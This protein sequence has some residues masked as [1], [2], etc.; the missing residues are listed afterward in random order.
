MFFGS[1]H[2]HLWLVWFLNFTHWRL[3]QQVEMNLKQDNGPIDLTAFPL[4]VVMLATLDNTPKLR[5]CVA[6]APKIILFC[7]GSGFFLD[8]CWFS[9]STSWWMWNVAILYKLNVNSQRKTSVSN[10]KKAVK[11]NF[12]CTNTFAFK[13]KN[14]KIIVIF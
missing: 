14:K 7:C 10:R 13:H 6:F 2:C 3:K 12:L 5:D 8:I 9:F 11:L 1:S 4:F